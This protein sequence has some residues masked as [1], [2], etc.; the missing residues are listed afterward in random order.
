MKF[1]H[2]SLLPALFGLALAPLTSAIAEDLHHPPEATTEAP[3]A[4]E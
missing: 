1:V 4:D 3:A 2:K